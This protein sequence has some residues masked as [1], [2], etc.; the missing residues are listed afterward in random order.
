MG[1]GRNRRSDGY[2]PMAGV[3]LLQPEADGQCFVANPSFGV[4]ARPRIRAERARNP[5]WSPP[6]RAQSTSWGG[7]YRFHAAT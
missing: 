1:L 7:L 4:V 5:S 2:D 6:F 3:L